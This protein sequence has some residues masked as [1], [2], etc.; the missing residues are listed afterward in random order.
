MNPLSND[1]EE[2]EIH[3]LVSDLEEG[4]IRDDDDDNNDNSLP[5][6]RGIKKLPR[7]YVIREDGGSFHK[8]E[9]YY[10]YAVRYYARK[11]AN[12]MNTPSNPNIL[13]LSW[14]PGVSKTYLSKNG[15]CFPEQS[16]MA[17]IKEI[18]RSSNLKMHK[19][20][21]STTSKSEE[22]NAKYY[23]NDYL[24][25]SVQESPEIIN[26]STQKINTLT[27]ENNCRSFEIQSERVSETKLILRSNERL[28]DA[29]DADNFVVHC[30]A[31]NGDVTPNCAD[32]NNEQSEDEEELRRI[33]LATCGRRNTVEF[34]DGV[35]RNAQNACTATAPAAESTA[36]INPALDNYEVV[37]MDIDE[38]EGNS[39]DIIT[40]TKIRNSDSTENVCV[41]DATTS[42]DFTENTDHVP[43]AAQL[44]G[45]ESNETEVLRTHF[46][47]SLCRR[48]REAG[49]RCSN[50]VHLNRKPVASKKTRVLNYNKQKFNFYPKRVRSTKYIQRANSINKV[51]NL[52]SNV[53]TSTAASRPRERL[54]IALNENS[55]EDSENCE[56]PKFVVENPIGSIVALISECRQ[57]SDSCAENGDVSCLSKSQQEEYNSLL[58][59]LA[60]KER[61]S[62]VPG[63]LPEKKDSMPLTKCEIKSLQEKMVKLRRALESKNMSLVFLS[64][65]VN[66]K[67][68]HYMKTKLFLKQQLIA[69]EKLR[70]I[71]LLDWSKA[72]DQLKSMK[73][74]VSDL[75]KKIDQVQ[76]VLQKVNTFV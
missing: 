20:L 34:S 44:A 22:L 2:D 29:T 64:D 39:V 32:I 9:K 15:S 75:Q 45:R 54:I 18:C 6:H 3:E 37:D 36:S 8:H 7:R 33:A 52:K 38:D 70:A 51:R 67:K 14:N 72:C 26:T 21:Q 48:K 47:E 76:N 19:L 63:L 35:S 12:M 41:I 60:E 61:L 40:S 30:D 59:L 46:I 1:L 16:S 42:P 50:T 23:E 56:H 57:K 53:N 66:A 10:E 68:C 71:K 74:S 5:S 69:A 28:D 58:A 43:T 55:S 31:K 62:S 24:A 49:I 13:N 4:E 65:N 27:S 25:E 11:L 73:R 17:E